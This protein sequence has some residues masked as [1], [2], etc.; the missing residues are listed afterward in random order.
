LQQAANDAFGSAWHH[1]EVLA[2]LVAAHRQPA[3]AGTAPHQAR[4]ASPTGGGRSRL[5]N[6]LIAG[7]VVV[8]PIAVGAVIALVVTGAFRPGDPGPL[9]VQ[10]GV[11]LTVTPQ[12]GGCNTSFVFTAEGS[13][14]GQGNLVY[15]WELSDGR[16]SGDQTRWVGSNDARFRFIEHWPFQGTR[17]TQ[18]VMTFRLISPNPVTLRQQITY[19]CT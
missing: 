15:R 19:A 3:A 5:I 7:T 2:A 16:T 10:P 8:V 17:T 9:V 1:P 6:G 12:Q 13:V 18:G 4:A 11:T 14:Q